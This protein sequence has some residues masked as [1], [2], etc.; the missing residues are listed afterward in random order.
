[1]SMLSG[2]KTVVIE[3]SG[4]SDEVIYVSSVVS[5][6]DSSI[7]QDAVDTIPDNSS[8]TVNTSSS[9]NVSGDSSVD[10]SN[11]FHEYDEGKIQQKAELFKAGTKLFT[12]KKCGDSYINSYPLESLK[13]LAIGNSYSVN[14]LLRFYSICKQAGIKEIVVATMFIPDCSLDMHW[15]NIQNNSAT[16]TLF[17]DTTGK[18]TE[19]ENYSIDKIINEE[20][21]DVVTL[22]NSS[23]NTGD[24]E[25]FGN[26]D[27]MVN[28]VKGKCPN[29][30]IMWHMTWAYQGTFSDSRFSPYD[31]DQMNMYK[32]II[33][34]TQ[35]IVLKNKDIYGVIPVGTAIQNIRSSYIGD[36]VNDDG[37]HLTPDIGYYVAAFTWYQALTGQSVYDFNYNAAYSQANDNREVI[38]ESV[39]NALKKPY[40][41]S[42]SS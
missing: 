14:A 36:T 31:Y 4:Y 30:K 12:C 3:D 17:K 37:L 27:N 21:W 19:T 9:E 20:E 5:E 8:N 35:N 29:A 7:V 18:M 22:Q 25:A 15:E 32:A 28:Y 41:L 13:V 26:L 24:P 16:Y 11:C 39:S 10:S 42:Y 23:G 38:L 33:D 6:N 40:E 34:C 2:C 1:M